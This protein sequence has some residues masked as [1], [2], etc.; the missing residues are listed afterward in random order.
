MYSEEFYAEVFVVAAGIVVCSSGNVV[1]AAAVI[2]FLAHTMHW[3]IF[4]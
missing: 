2:V 1:V 4:V 3:Q